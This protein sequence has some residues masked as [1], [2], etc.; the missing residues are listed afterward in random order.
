MPD[1]LVKLRGKI[2]QVDRQLVTLFAQRLQLVAAVGEVKNKTGVSVYA[3]EREASMLAQRRA[4]AEALG[5]PADLIED[6]LRRLMRESYL[7]ENDAGFK[8]LQ[9]DLGQIV[10][11]GGAG[12]LGR[13]FQ[14][15]FKRSGYQVVCFDKDDWPQ[16]QEIFADAGLVIIAVPIELTVAVIEQLPPLPEQ[17][18]LIDLTSVKE[19]PLAAMLQA[20]TGPV[21]GLH[22]MFG[23]D[24][25][26]LAKQVIIYTEGRDLAAFSCLLAQLQIWGA[27]LEAVSATT[28]D[29]AMSFIQAL[30]HFTSFAYGAH[31]C[32]EQA[33][34]AELLS[35]SSPIYRLELAMVGRLF[36]QDPN[37]YADIILSSPLN[38]KMIRRYHERFGYLLS[39]LEQGN[40]TAFVEQFTVISAF[41]GEYAQTF[42]AESR[43]LLAQ[44]NDKR[45][46]S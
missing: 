36:A 2:D 37:L 18:L 17:C 34:L 25:A 11:V 43:H 26:S 42:L 39:E 7:S 35:L 21:L 33:N 10:I 20:H 8:C 30:R 3:P 24:V 44:A 46:L 1:E 45:H 16:A 15:F 40:R 4:E 27:R 14:R 13:L 41:F 32:A 31:L 5:V 29:Q 12:K 19:A 22:P 9:P 38:L 23:P 6:V 28:H